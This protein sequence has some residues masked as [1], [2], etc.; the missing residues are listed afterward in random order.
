MPLSTSR[1]GNKFGNLD[2]GLKD[3]SVL[4][5]AVDIAKKIMPVLDKDHDDFRLRNRGFK[6]NRIGETRTFLVR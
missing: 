5:E 1:F 6:P 4:H 3:F 2:A